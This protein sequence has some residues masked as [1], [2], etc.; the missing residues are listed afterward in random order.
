MSL[1]ITRS[2]WAR[3]RAPVSKPL[4]PPIPIRTDPRAMPP[5][6]SRESRTARI[7]I[8]GGSGLETLAPAITDMQ[9]LETQKAGSNKELLKMAL[10]I[11]IPA[12][13]FLV[14]A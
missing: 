2:V 10:I 13:L 14:G 5:V 11:G 3:P 6:I 7:G 1:G 4:P 12:A 8:G 9:V